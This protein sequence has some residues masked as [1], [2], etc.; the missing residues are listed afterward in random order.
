MITKERL[1]ELIK[2]GA[3]IYEVKYQNINPVSLT[4]KVRFISDKNKVIV[5]EP[6]ADEKYLHH[7]Y[8]KNLFETQEEAEWHKEFGCIERT[9]R[10]EFP[11]YE[12]I[13]EGQPYKCGFVANGKHYQFFASVLLI[14]LLEMSEYEYCDEQLICQHSTKENYILACRKCKELFLGGDDE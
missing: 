2:Q 10:L 4:N 1:E 5:F 3:M 7:K 11:L 12:N 13:K 9:E 6:R 8:L 14:E